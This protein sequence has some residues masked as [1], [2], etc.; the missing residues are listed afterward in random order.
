[1]RRTGL[2]LLLPAF[3]VVGL[4]SCG[5]AKPKD[6]SATGSESEEQGFDTAETRCL[7]I[8]RGKRERLR[9]E[10]EKIVVKHVL[11]KFAGAKKAGPDIKRT[12]GDA[13][14]R[15]LEARRLLQNSEPFAAVVAEYSDEPGAATR[16]GTL[17][18]IKRSDVVPPFADAAFE[19][20]ANEVSHVVETDFGYH[21]I[22]RT[23]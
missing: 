8:A 22:L 5:G 20:K 15:A 21:I 9:D 1:M 3:L 4:L 2:L 12:R 14:V 11:V 18:E 16:E 23:Q 7:A 17:G 10:P 19:L 13:C 6:A